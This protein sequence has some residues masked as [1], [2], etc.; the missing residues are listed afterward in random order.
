MTEPR[1]F[2]IFFEERPFQWGLRGDPHVWNEMSEYFSGTPILDTIEELVTLI[3][4]AFESLTGHSISE[5]DNFYIERFSYG[6]LSSGMVSPE[7]WR[8]IAIPM[9][10]ER[11]EALRR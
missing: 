7:Y 10:R 2:A 1:T 6:G 4:R 5:K 9:L 8:D 3:E 11:F